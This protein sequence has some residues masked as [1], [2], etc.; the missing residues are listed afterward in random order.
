MNNTSFSSFLGRRWWLLFLIS[1]HMFRDG[2]ELPLGAMVITGGFIILL[3][4]IYW[5][6]KVR[7]KDI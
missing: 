5:Y 3:M 4:Y 6:V 7:R 1:I 2:E